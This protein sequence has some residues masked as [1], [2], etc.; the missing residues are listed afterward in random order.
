MVT[1]NR[2]VTFKTLCSLEVA[3]WLQNQNGNY[4]KV[5]KQNFCFV[6]CKILQLEQAIVEAEKLKQEEGDNIRIYI[7]KFEKL[8]PFFKTSLSDKVT[9]R[10]FLQ[11]TRQVAQSC[12]IKTKGMKL[13]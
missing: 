13:L 12:F 7:T 9:I 8:R 10:M 11:G 5:L 1:E 2:I 3:M 6:W 4:W